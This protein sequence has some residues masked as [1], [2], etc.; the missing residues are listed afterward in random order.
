VII[1]CFV[2]TAG[3]KV[4]VAE[5]AAIGALFM[6]EHRVVATVLLLVVLFAKQPDGFGEHIRPRAL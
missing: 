3:L 5:Q 4:V 2:P 6:V 1:Y